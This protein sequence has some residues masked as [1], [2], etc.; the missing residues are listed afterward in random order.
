MLDWCFGR[1]ESWEYARSC[2]RVAVKIVLSWNWIW[3]SSQG[4]RT[5][6]LKLLM[7]LFWTLRV[8]SFRFKRYSNVVAV[9]SIL[10]FTN[11]KKLLC[12]HLEY[13]LYERSLRSRSIGSHSLNNTLNIHSNSWVNSKDCV[14]RKVQQC[15]LLRSENALRWSGWCPSKKKVASLHWFPIRKSRKRCLHF[16]WCISRMRNWLSSR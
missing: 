6:V 14:K 15:S 11:M 2:L 9:A 10:R 5:N 7:I 16:R 13:P 12:S 4:S 1:Q 8:S 3:S